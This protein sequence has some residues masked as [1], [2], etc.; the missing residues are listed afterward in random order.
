M[1]FAVT[2]VQWQKSNPFFVDV[3]YIGTIHPQHF[4]TGKLF[5]NAQKNVLIEKPLGLN[6][7]QVQELITAAQENK[8]FLMEVSFFFFLIL[9]WNVVWYISFF[10]FND[11][12]Q[13]GHGSFLH[14]LKWEDSW[15]KAKWVMF[16][17]WGLSLGFQSRMSV[18]CQTT[19]WEEG[20]WWIWASTHCSLP[21]WFLKGRNQSPSMQVAIV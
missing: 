5:I 3:V 17:W 15:N 4:N 12:R 8:V 1:F 19:N 14:M 2:K 20:D 11:C 9:G 16:R 18:A 21:S 13:S 7:R 10:F 6:L